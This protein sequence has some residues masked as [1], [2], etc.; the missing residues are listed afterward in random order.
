MWAEGKGKPKSELWGNIGRRHKTTLILQHPTKSGNGTEPRVMPEIMFLEGQ[1]AGLWRCSQLCLW[2][3]KW[4]KSHLLSDF[5]VSGTLFLAE[6]TVC[7]F[8]YIKVARQS[9]RMRG[10]ETRQLV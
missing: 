7:L 1:W 9:L 2:A 10:L 3:R 6:F 8:Y 5:H 4:L